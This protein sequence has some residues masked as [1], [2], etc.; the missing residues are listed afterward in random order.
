LG[1]FFAGTLVSSSPSVAEVLSG[2]AVASDAGT[3]GSEGI[4]TVAAAGLSVVD[5]EV[6]VADWTWR[7]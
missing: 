5:P 2:A 3:G 4:A 7:S 6:V 1:G